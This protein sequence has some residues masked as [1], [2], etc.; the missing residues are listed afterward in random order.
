MRIAILED[1]P[2]QMQLLVATL[3]TLIVVGY[4]TPSCVQYTDGATLRSA[5]PGNPFD[6]FVL[7]WNMD[8]GVD[9]LQVL[10]SLRDK[11]NWTAP[12]IVLSARTSREDASEA[13]ACGAN[14]YFVKPVR[15]KELLARVRQLFGPREISQLNVETVW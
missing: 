7:D 9:G 10:R 5:L 3:E 2:I 15:P 12:A 11:G 14:E 8:G 4:D 1:E 13:L 6:L